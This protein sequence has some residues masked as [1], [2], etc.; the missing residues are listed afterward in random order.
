MRIP[1]LPFLMCECEAEHPEPYS[2][3]DLGICIRISSNYMSVNVLCLRLLFRKQKTKSYWVNMG[4]PMSP[5]KGRLRSHHATVQS[6]SKRRL[7]S[8]TKNPE[9]KEKLRTSTKKAAPKKTARGRP[10]GAAQQQPM[11]RLGLSSRHAGRDS[12]HPVVID[13]DVNG[14]GAA[15]IAS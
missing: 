14:V 7:P 6:L 10:A 11:A 9:E 5:W 15:V 13:D 3:T 2:N 12:E 8:R 4:T 1:S